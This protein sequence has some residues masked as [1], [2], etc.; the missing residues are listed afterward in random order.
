MGH[1]EPLLACATCACADYHAGR[2]VSPSA[3]PG[4]IQ[5]AQ[6]VGFPPPAVQEPEAIRLA[7]AEVAG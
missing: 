3:K 5:P 7:V 1:P 2:L 4:V 6:E